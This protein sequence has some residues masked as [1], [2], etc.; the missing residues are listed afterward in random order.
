MTP[1]Q[2]LTIVRIVAV[3]ITILVV[4]LFV[5]GTAYGDQCANGCKFNYDACVADCALSS[6]TPKLCEKDCASSRDCCLNTCKGKPCERA[7]ICS[8]CGNITVLACEPAS[9]G[10][11]W[12]RGSRDYWRCVGK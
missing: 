6:P 2:E 3:I 12:R 8:E 10:K 1:R 11:E 7:G 9:R 4:F 5:I